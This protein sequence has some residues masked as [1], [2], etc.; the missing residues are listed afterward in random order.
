M[1]NA[2]AIFHVC[3][4]AETADHHAISR[5]SKQTIIRLRL[6]APLLQTTLMVGAY[7]TLLTFRQF[8]FTHASSHGFRQ[9]SPCWAK[10]L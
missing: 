8:V 9:V 2:F 6:I 3:V 1:H 4:H 7:A 5:F 10:R